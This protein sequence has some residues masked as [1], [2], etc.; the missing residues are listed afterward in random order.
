[1]FTIEGLS[2]KQLEQ[3]A[4]NLR[5]T[6]DYNHLVSPS[7]LANHNDSAWVYEMVN[8]LKK[9]LSQFDKSAIKDYLDY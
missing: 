3:I 4:C 6:N 9:D 8:R 1:M 5:F 7:S 2:D